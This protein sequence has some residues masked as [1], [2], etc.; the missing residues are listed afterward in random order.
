MYYMH[1]EIHEQPS[2]IERLDRMIE[3][4]MI[5]FRDLFLKKNPKHI[6]LAARGSS[7][8]ACQYFRYIEEICYGLPVSFAAP[9]VVSVYRSKMNYENA[10]VIGV[11]QSGQAQ[12]VLLVMRE[13]KKQNAL[14]VSLT[15]DQTSPMALE[16]DFS[17]NLYANKELSVAATKTF[18]A[19]LYILAKIVSVMTN[20][21]FENELKRIPQFIGKVFDVEESIKK[22]AEQFSSTNLTYILA[23]GPLYAVAQETALKLL[24]TTYIH[25]KAYAT[26]DFHHGP[27][28]A[29]DESVHTIVFLE[30][31][32]MYQDLIE[33]IN[34]IELAHGKLVIF[35]NDESYINRNPVIYLPET[36]YI[37]SAFVF[38]CAIQ[39]FAYYVALSK[40]LNPDQPR[41]LKK[42]T[43]TK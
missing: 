43:I 33:M 28:A 5:M 10:L 29:I 21:A 42:V 1:Q 12:D 39:L 14:V 3:P 22:V 4:R 23:R 31:G 26:S 34:K 20:H 17:L 24:E 13:A 38:S 2:I 36:A 18:T 40:G 7:D 37:T 32:V 19:Q 11:S 16:A 25:A 6:I 9:S 8:H 27:F 30:K 35:T 15:N 41:G